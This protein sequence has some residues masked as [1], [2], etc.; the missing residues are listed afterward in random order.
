MTRHKISVTIS[1]DD[2]EEPI[3]AGSITVSGQ[4]YEAF[5]DAAARR[6]L[7]ESGLLVIGPALVTFRDV[8]VPVEKLDRVTVTVSSKTRDD[9]IRHATDSDERSVHLRYQAEQ[10]VAEAE[11][12]EAQAARLRA[13]DDEEPVEDD[14]SENVKR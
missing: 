13:A 1:R 7:I 6:H 2:R 11:A 12:L 8:I 14:G 10:L 4:D 3:S 5:D 9:P